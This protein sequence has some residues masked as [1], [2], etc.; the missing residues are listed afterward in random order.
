MMLAMFASD[1]RLAD[2]QCQPLDDSLSP[3]LYYVFM[4]LL[5]QA[6]IS[7]VFSIVFQAISQGFFPRFHVD[8]TSDHVS[9]LH[10]SKLC[11]HD[12]SDVAWPQ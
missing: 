3:M 10:P 6:L 8:H 11:L 9:P 5:L 7:A 1:L 2:L 12:I 4:S